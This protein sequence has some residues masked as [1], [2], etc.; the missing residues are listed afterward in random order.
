MTQ[1]F[2]SYLKFLQIYINVPEG[3]NEGLRV[4]TPNSFLIFDSSGSGYP[5][6]LNHALW[7]IGILLYNQATRAKHFA[8]KCM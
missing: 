6:S 1:I 7:N 3:E 8:P 4:A 2:V 5:P